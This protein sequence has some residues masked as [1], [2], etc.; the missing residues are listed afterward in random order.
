ML[1]NTAKKQMTQ[2]MRQLYKGNKRQDPVD[3]LH[4]SINTAD[5]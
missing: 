4:C 3:F 5:K 1:E 2:L